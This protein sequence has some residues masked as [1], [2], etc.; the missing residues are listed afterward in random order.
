THTGYADP[1]LRGRKLQRDLRLLE[2]EYAE[3]PHDPFTLFNLGSTCSEMRQFGRAEALLQ[4][5]LDRSH[6]RDSIVRNLYVLLSTC[7]LNQ[8]RPDLALQTCLQGQSVCP[9]DAELLFLESVLRAERD[10]LH[11]AKTALLRLLCSAPDQHFAS[12]L[13]GLRGP[14]GRQQLA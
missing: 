14:K 6:P 7:Q 10:D 1:A 12:V 2:Q 3:Q 4:E 5:S 13:D 8:G 9:D 11:G